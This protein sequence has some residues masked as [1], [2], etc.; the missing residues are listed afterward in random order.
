MPAKKKTVRKAAASEKVAT[1][2]VVR[3]AVK[4][5]VAEKT[6]KKKAAKKVV[7]AAAEKKVKEAVKSA[8]KKAAPKKGATKVI[9]TVDIS[10]AAYL[11]Y[12][13]RQET[14]TPGTPEGDW[15]E[16]ERLLVN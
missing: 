7:K 13:T 8:A 6:V 16:A 10:Q 9:T 11:L 5:S 4:K 15:L 14:G 12:L 3:K 2:R 1:K